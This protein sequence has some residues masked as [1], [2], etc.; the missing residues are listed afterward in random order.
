MQYQQTMLSA[1]I[2]WIRS[3]Q[4]QLGTGQLPW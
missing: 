1:E 3:L 4:D 2:G